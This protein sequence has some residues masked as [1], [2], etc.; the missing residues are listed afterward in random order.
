MDYDDER[1]AV[2]IGALPALW[3]TLF[4]LHNFYGVDISPMADRLATDEASIL[5]CLDEA[6]MMVHRQFPIWEPQHPCH[7]GQ[8]RR[9]AR[10]PPRTTAAA[11]LSRG[12]RRDLRRRRL[13]RHHIMACSLHLRRSR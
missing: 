10:S 5:V 9:I 1:H 12:G 4:R 11:R 7:P 6:R 13:C 2:A 3:R 8:E